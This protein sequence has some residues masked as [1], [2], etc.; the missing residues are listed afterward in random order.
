MGEIRSSGSY[1]LLFNTWTAWANT[2]PTNS[3]ACTHL[4]YHTPPR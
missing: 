4:E 3:R 1:R 2:V